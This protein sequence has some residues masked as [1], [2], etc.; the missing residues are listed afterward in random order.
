MGRRPER[1]GLKDPS[2]NV[3]GMPIDDG[4]EKLVGEGLPS[5]TQKPRKL[6]DY[7]ISM[8]TAASSGIGK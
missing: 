8:P 2:G 4:D 7:A 6:K 3:V 5:R 1:R